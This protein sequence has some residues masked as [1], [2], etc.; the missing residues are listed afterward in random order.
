V[1]GHHESGGAKAAA[2]FVEPLASGSETGL[3]EISKLEIGVTTQK[4]R[5]Q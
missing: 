5:N 4:E 3:N 2:L 1:E